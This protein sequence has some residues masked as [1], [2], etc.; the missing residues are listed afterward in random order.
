MRRHNAFVDVVDENGQ[1]V[2]DPN[3][4]IAWSWEGRQGDQAAPPKALDKPDNEPAGDVPIE[5]NMNLELWLEGDGLASDHVVNMH[6]RHPDENGSNGE[7]QNTIGHHSFYLLFQRTRNGITAPVVTNGGNGATDHPVTPPQPVASRPAF[8][9]DY[10]YGLHEMGGEDL[11]VN[12]GRPGWVLELAAVGLDGG[13]PADFSALAQKKLGVV[14][15]LNHGYGSSGTLPTRD[16]YDAF[17]NACA[18]YVA[19]S[20]GCHVWIIGNEP[21]HEQ[22]RPDGQPITPDDYVQAYRLCRNKIR[23]LNGHAQDLVLV[24]GPAPWN[25]QTKYDRNPSGDWGKYF[26]DTLALLGDGECDGFAVHTYTRAHDPS[27][28]A[29][30]I[31]FGNPDFRHLRDEFRT[32]RDWMERIPARF[33]TLPVLITESDPT[34]ANGWEPAQNLGWIQSAYREIADWNRNP[35]NQPIQ[36]LILYRW[37]RRDDQPQWSLSNRPGLID[38][39]NAALR[40]EPANDYRLRISKENRLLIVPSERTL[41]P[42]PL[43]YTNQALINAFANAAGALGLASWALLEKAGLDV[44]ILAADRTGLYG[45]TPLESLPNLSVAER[46]VVRSELLNQLLKTPR[47]RGLVAAQD[48]L[49]LRSGPGTQNAVIKPLAHEAA[50]DVLAEQGT[51]LFVVADG[52]AGY[53][54]SDFVIRPTVT[55]PTP[56]PVQ[57]ESATTLAPSADQLMVAP[58]NADAN[59]VAVVNTWNRY[60]GLLAEQAKRLGIDPAIAVAVLVAESRGAAFGSDGRLIIRFEA[61][62][63]LHYCSD[64]SKARAEQCFRFD[65]TLTYREPRQQMWRRDPNGDWQ[66]CHTGQQADEWIVFDFARQIDDNAALMAI[67]MGA[68]QVMGFNYATVGYPNVHAMFDAFRSSERSQIESLFRFMEVNGLVD[69][70]RNKEFRAF[71]KGYN[72]SDQIDLYAGIIQERLALFEA[73]RTPVPSAVP[74]ALALPA[75]VAP[76]SADGKPLKESDPELYQAWADHIKQGFVNNN[77]MFNRILDGFMRPYQTTIWMYRILFGVG[78]LAFLAAV[79]MALIKDQPAAAIG[80]SLVFGGLSVLAFLSYFVSRP[81][82]ALEENLQFITWLGIVYNTYWARLVNANDPATV[83]QELEDATT[84]AVTSI[85]EMLDKHAAFSRQ[86]P[87]LTP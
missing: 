2:R 40:V 42:L 76:V 9:P 78:I 83:Q 54:H 86:R 56:Q 50:V 69:S 13:Q 68:P 57:G 52:D 11:M 19:R 16:H 58:P 18:T 6:P 14:V 23:G 20:A 51:W 66:I 49:M 27:R 71:A 24:A 43:I 45:A 60:G 44:A 38:D 64:Q 29:Q 48:G 37:P 25:I 72:G 74:E 4:R 62:I 59:T 22:E 10:I 21:N 41:A 53:V 3:L 35:N 47:W 33:R 1:R 73:L 63:F 28:I 87:G 31:P 55:A 85:K 5:K 65:P 61:H 15:R 84:D 77:I 7:A 32:Y 36:A 67:S 79:V 70:V 30:D 75:P 34:D 39:W 46:A 80:T 12:A 17:A 8:F 81:M 82:Q 26:A